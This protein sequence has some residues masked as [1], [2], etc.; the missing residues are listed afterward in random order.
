MFISEIILFS[1]FILISFIY[2]FFMRNHILKK[3]NSM[4][5]KFKISVII[6]ARNEEKNIK[7]I[8]DSLIKQTADIYE[9]IVVDDCSEDRT[10]EYVKMYNNV[11]LITLKEDPPK[12]W[13]GKSWA[14]WNGFLNSEGDTFLFADADTEFNKNAVE[15]IAQ[16]YAE[17]R[18]LISVWPYQRF[19]RLYEHFTF[20]FNLM[21][22]HNSN[23]LGF[24][25]KNPT[26]AFGPVIFTGREEYEKTG[27]HEA[28]KN[29]VLDDI[30]L[31]KLYLKNNYNV[32]NYMGNEYVKF[33]MYPKGFSQMAEGFSKNFS[34][35]AVNGGLLNF[36]IA[37]IWISVIFTSFM[38]FRNIF[39]TII[40]YLTIV[41]FTFVLSR[42]SGDY[43]WYD[44]IFYPVH[45]ICFLIIFFY[46]LYITVFLHKVKWRGRE[47]SV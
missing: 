13:T 26:G 2:I 36:F 9:I 4:Y 32:S 40:R 31:G 28:I 10:A 37:F 20:S 45:F 22:L 47:I 38:S 30:K 8:L 29:F 44:Y 17:K 19:E 7:K 41:F 46:S 3:D 15:V 12:G 11:K 18:G 34:S 21:A 33:R 1:A 35:G 6:P 42:K 39:F 25:F 23:M 27:G 24:P 43:K 16:K 14:L 5:G